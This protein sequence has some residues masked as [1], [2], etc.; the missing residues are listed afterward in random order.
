FSFGEIMKK[1]G[2]L[3]FIIAL[4]IGVSLAGIFSFGKISSRIFNISINHGEK[5]SGNIV[6]EKREVSEFRAVDVGGA[7]VVEITAQKD[8]SLEVEA[9]DNILPLIKTEFDGE[10]LKIKTDVKISSSN[11]VKIRISA[12]DVE[13]LQISG[14]SKV[15]IVNLDNELLNVDLSGASKINCEGQ[16]KNLMIDM[17]GASSLDGE[18]L[19]AENV[20]IEASGASK[21]TVFAKNELKADLSGASKVI[22]FANPTNIEKKTSGASSI[23]GK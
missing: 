19:K 5:G 16:T 13:N 8:Y 22:Y 23:V 15:S 14:A 7:F 1:F 9:D 21:A 18:N 20:S 2:V 17:S 12:P 6:T 3:I 10:T 4:F 11:P